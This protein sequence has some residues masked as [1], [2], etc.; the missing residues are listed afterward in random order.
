MKV[1]VFSRAQAER[2]QALCE[3]F[4]LLTVATEAAR[5][6]EQAGQQ[7]ALPT[8]LEVFELEAQ[9]R[10][11]RRI[12]RLRAAAKLPPGKTFATLDETR[13]PRPLVQQLRT[14][15]TGQFL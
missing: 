12:A 6:F 8:L 11:E 9:D 10:H 13:L 15:S 3:Q 4:R 14:L 7:E 1:A 2:L 5:R